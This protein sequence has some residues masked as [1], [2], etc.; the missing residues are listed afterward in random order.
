MENNYNDD[1]ESEIICE[2]NG[3]INGANVGD[4][5]PDFN[6]D[7]IANGTGTFTL[8]DYLGEIVVLAFFSPS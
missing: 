2:T 6:L 8:S 7:V 5:A 4:S 3:N 1:D